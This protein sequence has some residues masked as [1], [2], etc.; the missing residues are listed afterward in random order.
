MQA[1]AGK[2]RAQKHAAC[3]KAHAG[4]QKHMAK[5]SDSVVPKL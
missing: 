5:P 4:A 2:E 3:Q 1:A